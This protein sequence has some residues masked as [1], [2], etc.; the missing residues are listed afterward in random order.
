M[1]CERKA[2]TVHAQQGQRGNSQQRQKTET[3]SPLLDSEEADQIPQALSQHTQLLLSAPVC[4]HSECSSS[5]PS[6]LTQLHVPRRPYV[7]EHRTREGHTQPQHK[8]PAGLARLFN[9][10]KL[11]GAVSVAPSLVP[12][13][14]EWGPA[15]AA[16]C[17]RLPS[18]GPQRDGSNMLIGQSAVPQFE[19]HHP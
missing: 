17:A 18:R 8:V 15:F 1:Q 13:P 3:L 12:Q 9:V 5:A 10:Q 2:T 4:T 11:V 14:S 7:A 16:S 19:D 6:P